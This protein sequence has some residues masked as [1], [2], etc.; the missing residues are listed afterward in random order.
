M[1]A[2][3][4]IWY[5]RCPV[6]TASG[7]AFQRRTFDKAFAGTP[8]EVRNIKEL[9]LTGA[10]THFDH[11]LDAS[12]REGGGSPPMWARARGGDTQLLGITFMDEILGI[13]VR[14]DDSARTVADL[15]GRRSAR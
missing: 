12:F 1:P 9:G 8:Y 4:T 10:N 2:T 13:F 11:S 7:I 3:T 15:A 14:A 6:P 5:T